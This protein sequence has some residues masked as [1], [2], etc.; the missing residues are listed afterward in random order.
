MDNQSSTRLNNIHALKQIAFQRN[1]L[2]LCM[3][4][5]NIH[6]ISMENTHFLQ[7]YTFSNVPIEKTIGIHD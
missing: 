4:E 6:S 7:Y 2:M 5:A 1:H 3:Q